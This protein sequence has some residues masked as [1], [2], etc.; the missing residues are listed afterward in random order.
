MAES[1]HGP[2]SQRSSVAFLAAALIVVGVL[3]RLPTSAQF[4]LDNDWG[5]QLAGAN[6]ILH[7]E[8]PFTDWRNDYGPLAFY[9]SALAQ[10]IFGLRPIGEIVLCLGAY[11]AGYWLLYLSAFKLTK[12]S[13][14]SMVAI[15]LALV[16]MPRPYKYYVVL[17]PAAVVYAMIR[18]TEK[19]ARSSLWWLAFAVALAGLF[20]ADLGGYAFIGAAVAVAI[21][22]GYQAVFELLAACLVWCLP[23]LLFAI[24]RHGLAE[25]LFDSTVGASR[26]AKGQS[27]PVPP[28]GWELVLYGLFF[29]LPPALVG[30]LIVRKPEERSARAALWGLAVFAGLLLAQATHRAGYH[31]LVQAIPLCFVIATCGLARAQ[32]HP[33]GRFTGPTYAWAA[34][35]LAAGIA[36][37]PI[38]MAIP[39][40]DLPQM[41]RDVAELSK[42]RAAFLAD[43]LQA[44]GLGPNGPALEEVLRRTGEND[45][46]LALPLL[47]NYNYLTGRP[48]GGDQMLLMNGYF[49]TPEDQRRMIEAMEAKPVA[50]VLIEPD[51]ELDGMPSRKIRSYAPL[52]ESYFETN[53]AEVARYG[54]IEVLVRRASR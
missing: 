47:T 18:Y 22:G 8:H 1:A 51:L 25:Y 16:L 21:A 31:H 24:S 45:R 39:R 43:A 52:L 17:C 40:A 44:G 50:M 33:A 4:V 13:A 48:F 46:I 2:V 3:S 41:A 5:H 20:R 30:W 28:N 9:A 23:W 29:L 37:I 26:H 11:I 42:P 19:P 15:F 38:S 35:A 34:L 36:L 54:E 7:G 49:S 27:L 32:R 10:W 53:Y 12:S 14:A 6:Q